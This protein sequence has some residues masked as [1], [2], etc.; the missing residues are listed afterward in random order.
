[1]HNVFALDAPTSYKEDVSNELEIPPNGNVDEQLGLY[2]ID[3]SR[4]SSP[5]LSLMSSRS[6]D[7]SE[8]KC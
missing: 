3:D 7:F 6:L 8:Q 5:V 4:F 2:Q 1:M